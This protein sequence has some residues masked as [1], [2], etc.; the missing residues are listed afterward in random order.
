MD[1][2]ILNR[3][4]ISSDDSSSS[5]EEGNSFGD[6][7]MFMSNIQA[8]SYERNRNKLFTKDIIKKK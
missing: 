2:V 5:E 4:L 7:T 8:S 6:N 1:N 3:E